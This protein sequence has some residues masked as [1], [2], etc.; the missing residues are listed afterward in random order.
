MQRVFVYG[1]LKSGY[2]NHRVLRSA[3]FIETTVKQV[4][5][6]MVSLGAFPALVP[7]N[8][9]HDMTGEVYEVD[10]DTMEDLDRLEGFPTFYS[11]TQ[12]D[13]CWVYY[14]TGHDYSR[15]PEVAGGCWR[16]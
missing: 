7:D 4:P 13:G 8:S 12:I 1:T 14:L 5:F 16:D 6:R 2:Y 3:K 9:K 11:R 10:A 15:Y